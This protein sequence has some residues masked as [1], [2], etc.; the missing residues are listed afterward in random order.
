MHQEEIT[1]WEIEN[2]SSIKSWSIAYG[3]EFDT[4]IF[5]LNDGQEKEFK[6]IK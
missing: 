5:V 6:R 4:I 3:S 1:K 2:Q